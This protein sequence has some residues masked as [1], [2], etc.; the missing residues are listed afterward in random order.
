MPDEH[1]AIFN[2]LILDMG[3]D[4]GSDCLLLKRGKGSET[5]TYACLASEA[6][7]F[8]SPEARGKWIAALE[9]LVGDRLAP[10]GCLLLG[11]E[12]PP[13]STRIASFRNA[14]WPAGY[15][16]P[17]VYVF[18]KAGACIRLDLSGRRRVA[19]AG[20]PPA[21]RYVIAAVR[22]K[23][24]LTPKAVTEKFDRNAGGWNGDPESSLYR[25]FRWMRRIMAEAAGPLDGKTI[26]DAGCGAGWVGIE[27]AL[28]GGKVSAF[29]PSPEMVRL[30]GENGR[31]SGVELDVKVGFG[32]RPPFQGPF[33]IVIS[34]GVISFSLDQE[35]FLDGL[36]SMV[37]EGGLLV[38][39]DVNP[40]SL[41]MGYR[42]RRHP[43]LPLRELNGIA[44][45]MIVK[46]LKRR[47]YLIEKTGYYQLTLPVPALMHICETKLG[48][49]G[50]SILLQL[51]KCARFIASASGSFATAFF[52]SYVIR[53][54]KTVPPVA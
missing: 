54:R 6:P 32:E 30:A 35:G 49:M 45:S 11:C 4:P 27:A 48:G 19:G 21:E 36:D 15:H 38:I 5:K 41:G 24:A 33:D 1:Q 23:D 34:S 53:A 3:L 39:G 2:P 18:E 42:R 50:A 46:M 40:C 16:V 26:L 12:E 8:E 29:D 28:S 25:H 44:G 37:K 14:L 10:G 17:A 22:R 9:P 43:V 51:N 13:T 52:D 47:G 31:I 7:D 20:S